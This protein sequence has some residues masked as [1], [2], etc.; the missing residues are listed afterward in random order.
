MRAIGRRSDMYKNMKAETGDKNS[1]IKWETKND[2]TR[3]HV[4]VFSC[5]YMEW[6]ISLAIT[7]IFWE[8]IPAGI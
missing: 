3:Q 7:I 1:K 5:D 2:P 4:F 6:I 8:L